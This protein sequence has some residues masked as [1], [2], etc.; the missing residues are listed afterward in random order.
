MSTPRVDTSHIKSPRDPMTPG[1][2]EALRQE[3]QAS[4]EA[5]WQTV[6][7]HG[8]VR[9]ELYEMFGSP[10]EDHGRASYCAAVPHR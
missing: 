4:S 9:D 7:E 2:C 5:V 1:E 8:S 6:R 10:W 3:L